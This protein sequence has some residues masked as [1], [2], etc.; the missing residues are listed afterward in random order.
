MK[1]VG[2]ADDVSITVIAKTLKEVEMS[3]TEGKDVIVRW[4]KS[5]AQQT[6][7]LFVSY[8]KVAQRTKN[9]GATSTTL[10]KEHLRQ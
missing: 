1:F 3:V 8:C 7:L 2:F 5:T 10:V 6:K 4:I 9:L